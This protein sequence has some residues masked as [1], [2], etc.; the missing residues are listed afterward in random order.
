MFTLSLK[1]LVNISSW[2]KLI[3]EIFFHKVILTGKK[4]AP[5]GFIVYFKCT[6]KKKTKHLP[7]Q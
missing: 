4:N 5:V 2:L 7:A 3:F 1:I 6:W